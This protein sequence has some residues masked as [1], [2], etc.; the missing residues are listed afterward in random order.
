VSRLHAV[1]R[2][3]EGKWFFQDYE[4]RNGSALRRGGGPDAVSLPAH[5]AVELLV[6]DVVEL[7]TPEATLEVLGASA[8][9]EAEHRAQDAALTSE[10]ARAFA[11]RIELAARTRVPVFLL[12][13]SGSG[14]THT[15]RQIHLRS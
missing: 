10:V 2:Q 4:S 8:L 15:A 1:L 7:G 3:E 13:P 14:K 12:G 6:G 9:P 11:A 5:Q